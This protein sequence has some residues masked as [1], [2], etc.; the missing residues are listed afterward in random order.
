MDEKTAR[1]VNQLKNNPA[2]LQA[3][4]QSKDGKHLMELLTRGD[5]GAGLQQAVRSAAKG[6]PAEMV[7]MMQK[8]MQS[9]EGAAL[10][11]RINQAIQ[12]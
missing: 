10:V 7:D 12:K 9:P 8:L 6:N 3:L 1:L 11:Q 2:M 5:R 4:M